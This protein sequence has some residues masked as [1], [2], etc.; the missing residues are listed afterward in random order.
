M[1]NPVF[2][3]VCKDIAFLSGFPITAKSRKKQ[4][5]KAKYKISCYTLI[6]NI[7]R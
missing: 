1:M 5:E 4:Q 7:N 2:I 6:I 3:S